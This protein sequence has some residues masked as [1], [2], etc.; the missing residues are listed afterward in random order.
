M[1][2][3]AQVALAVA[4]LC[5]MPVRS[6][7]LATLAFGVHLVSEGGAGRLVFSSLELPANEVKNKTPM[8]FDIPPRIREDAV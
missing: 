7:N 6:Q 2:A 5:Y 8:A 3:K 1:L 4:I